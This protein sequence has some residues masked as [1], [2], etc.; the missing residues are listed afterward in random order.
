MIINKH[1]KLSN[2]KIEGDI[3][4]ANINKRREKIYYNILNFNAQKINNGVF[5]E[6]ILR[7]SLNAINLNH[8][9]KNHPHVDIAILNEIPG[10]VKKNEIISVKS[11]ISKGTGVGKVISDTKSIRL[12]SMFSYIL[13]ANS[14]Y[15]LTYERSYFN[16]KDILNKSIIKAYE[17]GNK[18]YKE[19]LNVV[20]YYLMFKN[21]MEF[22][23]DLNSDVDILL[24]LSNT[25]K[26]EYKN[27][28]LKFGTY[29]EYRIE[30][31]KRLLKLDSPISL[32]IIYLEGEGDNLTCV[33]NKTNSIN[34]SRYWENLVDIW[35][36]RASEAGVDL[37][38]FF[39]GKSKYLRAKDINKL[40]GIDSF[41][42]EIKITIGSYRPEFE[43][44]SDIDK[45][46]KLKKRT[47]LKTNKLYVAT[48]FKD[49]NFGEEEEE[50]NSFFIDTIDT[51]EENPKLIKKFT[52][53]LK[54]IKS[55]PKLD[56]WW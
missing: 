46:N 13:Y 39:E 33:I 30:V 20:T 3:L 35:I 1:Y 45:E 26:S 5:A 50:V 44:F 49:A 24:K 8:L 53:F 52:D 29:K 6:N 34:V 40:F 23:N 12:E 41:P 16:P 10:I 25:N 32:G 15:E 17:N 19:I 21:K 18:N 7:I 55:P 56:K 2:D 37:K 42:V 38:D 47:E 54:F 36:G 9:S 11:S 48:Q 43:L 14:N 31:L 22:E 51:L 4:S 27:I 28:D